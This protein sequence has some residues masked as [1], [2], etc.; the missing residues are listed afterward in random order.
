ARLDLAVDVVAD[1]R[2]WAA[3]LD[4]DVDAVERYLASEVVDL[5]LDSFIWTRILRYDLHRRHDRP[6]LGRRYAWQVDL[7]RALEAGITGAVWSIT[8]NPFRP[9]R[10]R[11]D[12][13]AKNR[14]RL[15]AELD[16][17]PSVEV[18]RSVAAY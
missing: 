4:I 11:R 17:H 1:P 12:A 18:V 2:S 5:H 3:A 9:A 8:T 14:A 16:A 15:V 13:F 7:P 10:A 6:P